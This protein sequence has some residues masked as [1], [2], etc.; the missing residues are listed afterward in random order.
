M[1]FRITNAPAVALKRLFNHIALP[2]R[3]PQESDSN[4]DEVERGLVD[5]LIAAAK[6]M[7][8]PQDGTCWRVWDS[9]G[10][11]LLLCR[12]LNIGGKLERSQLS[13]HLKELRDSGVIILH[14]AAQNAG[15]IISKPNE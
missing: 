13:L 2:A 7:R 14:I 4:I 8:D 3:L 10:R 1:S 6:L 9:L 5:Y 15:I 11:S 12:A